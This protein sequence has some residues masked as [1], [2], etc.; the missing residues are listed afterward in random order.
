VF[1]SCF[2]SASFVTILVRI[3]CT[4]ATTANR[5]RCDEEQATCQTK[6]ESDHATHHQDP[7]TT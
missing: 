3:T 1:R 2:A 5:S 6:K 7:A 4:P